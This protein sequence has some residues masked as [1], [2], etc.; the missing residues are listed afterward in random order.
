MG[1]QMIQI[2]ILAAIALFLI[3]RLRNVLGTREGYE[4]PQ[5]LSGPGPARRRDRSFEVIEGGSAD[6]DVAD[7][8]DPV[9]PAGLALTEMKRI[10][11]SFSVAEFSHGARAAYEMIVMAY[12]NGDLETLRQFLSP[13]VYEPF[14]A[15]I[16]ARNAK[17][18]K[19][20]A[21]FAGIREVKLLDAHFDP[22]TNEGDI[23][24]RF[25]GELTSVVRDPEGRIVEG[26]PNELK[27]Q[28]DV[29]TFSRDMTSEDPNWRLTG[30]GG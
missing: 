24:M 30:T 11:R 18:Y 13:E 5:E 7:F 9:S 16:E 21:T 28:K 8:V 17:G 19:V 27:Q 3:L 4:K 23:T 6:P 10:D 14:A 22:A 2:I 15:A 1:S 20:E 29:W 25:V 12:E 26:A